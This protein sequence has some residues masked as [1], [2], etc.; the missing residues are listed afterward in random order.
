M[1][2]IPASGFRLVAGS[3]ISRQPRIHDDRD[4]EACR[5]FFNRDPRVVGA[6][7]A[8]TPELPCRSTQRTAVYESAD[9]WLR[10]AKAVPPNRDTDQGCRSNATT[11]ILLDARRLPLDGTQH[12]DGHDRGT[13]SARQVVI[14]LSPRVPDP[15]TTLAVGE[16]SRFEGI[17][18][19]V[20]EGLAG[21]RP[22]IHRLIRIQRRYVHPT[23]GH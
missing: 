21:Q 22:Q 10:T 5:S 4:A 8:C 1:V 6:A 19:H 18:A 2:G 20:A 11:S 16:M 14:E 7:S 13:N 3:S 9:C 17:A 23:I 15:K 12:G